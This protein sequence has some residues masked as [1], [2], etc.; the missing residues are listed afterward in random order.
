MDIFFVKNWGYINEIITYILSYDLVFHLILHFGQRS[1]IIHGDLTHKLAPRDTQHLL[2]QTPHNLPNPMLLDPYMISNFSTPVKLFLQLRFLEAELLGQRLHVQTSNRYWQTILKVAELTYTS[3]SCI[4][5]LIS[6]Q[7]NNLL[8][9]SNVMDEK[10]LV[11]AWIR[12]FPGD[13]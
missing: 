1:R 4:K 11:L 8:I 3:Q 13:G 9:V 7:G 2:V 12:P 5:K 10:Y 6:L